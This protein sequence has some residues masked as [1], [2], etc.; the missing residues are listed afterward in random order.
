V[1]P[2]EKG[3]E[4]VARLKAERRAGAEALFAPLSAEE[5]AELLRLLRSITKD[6]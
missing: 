5:K 6:A 2:T 1:T 3:R 4:L